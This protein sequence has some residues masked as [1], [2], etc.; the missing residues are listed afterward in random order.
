MS[1]DDNFWYDMPKVTRDKIRQAQ[2]G[3]KNGWKPELDKLYEE[4]KKLVDKG[5]NV[6]C[7]CRATGIT[8]DQYYRRRRIETQGKDRKN[9]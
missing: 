7:A 9:D 6:S 3:N 5:V 2:M 1:S 4:T 8:R